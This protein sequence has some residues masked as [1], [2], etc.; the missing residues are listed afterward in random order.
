MNK[1]YERAKLWLFA[2]D[3]GTWASHWGQGLVFFFVGYGLISV[4]FGLGLA[5]GAFAHRELSNF[6]AYWMAW[7]FKQATRVKFLDGWMDYT[8]AVL[9]A[10]TGLLFTQGA[11]A[12]FG[13]VFG[14]V[15]FWSIVTA[16]VRRN[17]AG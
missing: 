9:G 7:G 14:S 16:Y 15:A 12:G 8:M 1:L 5:I 17:K 6:V 4:E 3:E 2:T 10:V 11:A 13:G